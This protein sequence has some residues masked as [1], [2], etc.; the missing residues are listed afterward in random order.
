[1]ARKARELN[2]QDALGSVKKTGCQ[3]QHKQK[4]KRCHGLSPVMMKKWIR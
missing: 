4:E 2:D 3:E 1:L